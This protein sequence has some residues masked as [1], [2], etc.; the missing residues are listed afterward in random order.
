MAG[1]AHVRPMCACMCVSPRAQ[2]RYGHLLKQQESLVRSMEQAV[3]RRDT[4]A[5]SAQGRSQA[6][7]KLLTET[8]FHNKL[9]ELRRKIKESQKVGIGVGTA[10]IVWP[11]WYGNPCTGQ[12]G[13]RWVWGGH[14]G[15][16]TGQCNPHPVTPNW[17]VADWT[18]PSFTLEPTERPSPQPALGTGPRHS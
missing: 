6:N 11:W 8:D 12:H 2:V 3:E 14:H 7:S 4:I 1:S 5:A 10:G 9:L 18:P 16:R 15:P 13:P 17:E